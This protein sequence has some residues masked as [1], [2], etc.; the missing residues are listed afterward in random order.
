MF[1]KPKTS[2]KS[3]VRELGGQ[4][5]LLIWHVCQTQVN[6]G[7]ACFPDPS[8]LSLTCLPDPRCLDLA[9]ATSKVRG[10]SR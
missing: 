4:P 9:P 8:N 5:G 6:V 3:K 7:H 1:I 2:A 10:F